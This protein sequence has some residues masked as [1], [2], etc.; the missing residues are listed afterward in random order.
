MAPSEILEHEGPRFA[1]RGAAVN[2]AA[3]RSFV[4]LAAR[5]ELVALD[6]QHPEYH[7]KGFRQPPVSLM[8]VER[9]TP[10]IEDRLRSCRCFSPTE[11]S[12]APRQSRTC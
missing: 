9:I 2:V 4:W 12:I 8:P 7:W 3:L 1:T 11:A 5:A 6:W 10:A